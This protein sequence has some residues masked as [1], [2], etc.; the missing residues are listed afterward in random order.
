MKETK[1]KQITELKQLLTHTGEDVET[2]TKYYVLLP[3]E[4]AHENYHPT[5][6]LAGFAQRVQPK[7]IEKIS[8]LVG[9][10]VT[11]IQ[12][13]KRALRHYV[14]HSL[15]PDP[16]NCPNETNRAYYPTYTDIK[17][18]SKAC[19]GIVKVRSRQS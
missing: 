12:E 8:T 7:F 5:S 19:T 3:T 11:E 2:E 4:Q 16:S 10:G 6:G 15:F 14:V 18:L 9:E 13:V 17:I 1:A